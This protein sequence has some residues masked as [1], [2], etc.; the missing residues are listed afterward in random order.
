MFFTKQFTT[1]PDDIETLPLFQTHTSSPALGE[2]IT[3]NSGVW[4]EAGWKAVLLARAAG[5]FND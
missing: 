5:F 2:I 4:K 3:L 1:V